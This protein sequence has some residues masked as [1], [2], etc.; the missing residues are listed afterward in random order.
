[1]SIVYLQHVYIWL[2]S[3][4][5]FWCRTVNRCNTWIE[6]PIWG[7]SLIFIMWPMHEKIQKCTWFEY[8]FESSPWNNKRVWILSPVQNLLTTLNAHIMKGDTQRKKS[9]RLWQSPIPEG[10]KSSLISIRYE[11]DRH[12][13]TGPSVSFATKF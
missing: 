2:A 13:S 7:L 4:Y 9:L 3:E 6:F 8:T 10:S 11:Q 5:S 12:V 1:M